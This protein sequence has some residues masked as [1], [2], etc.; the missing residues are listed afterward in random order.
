MTALKAAMTTKAPFIA[1]LPIYEIFC[2]KKE[3]RETF[4]DLISRV[5]EDDYRIANLILK[6][7]IF[8]LA[9]TMTKTQN[10]TPATLEPAEHGPFSDIAGY[11]VRKLVNKNRT[12]KGHSSDGIQALLQV[13]KSTE[14]SNAFISARIRGGLVYVMTLFILSIG[15]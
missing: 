13:M 15:C 6:C 11:I 10:E 8:C 14:A 3:S 1:L 2:R 5:A 7:L 9:S 12:K 4:C